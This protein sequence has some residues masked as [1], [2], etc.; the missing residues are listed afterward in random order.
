MNDLPRPCRYVVSACLAG[1][2]CRY[3]GR[4]NLRPAIAALVQ[5]GQALPVCPEVLGGL[6]VPRTPCE[7]QGGRVVSADGQDRTAE[8]MTGA[9]AALYI[10][11]EYGCSAAILKARS[12]SCGCGRIY[13]GTFS[14]TLT[15]GDGL[16]AALLR[17]KGFPLFTEETFSP[18]TP[19]EQP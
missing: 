11:E 3:D 16:F 15:D 7:Q 8:F 13:D 17:K 9:E 1:Q 2:P 5:E 10:A 12:P 18:E 14:R 6:P 4:S 19:A